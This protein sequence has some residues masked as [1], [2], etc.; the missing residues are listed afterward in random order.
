MMSLY[1][2]ISSREP[3][4]SVG[5][6]EGPNSGV[7]GGPFIRFLEATGRPLGI[8]F[9]PEAWRSRVRSILT[10]PDEQI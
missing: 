4:T 2:Q 9:S 3:A 10:S 1:R 8:E 6:P 7:A 5:G